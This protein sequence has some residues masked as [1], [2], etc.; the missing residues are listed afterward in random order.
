MALVP[1]ISPQ[2]L[3]GVAQIKWTPTL[4]SIQ[5]GPRHYLTSLFIPL[6]HTCQ[7]KT[8]VRLPL[9][10]VVHPPNLL[11][12]DDAESCC[13]WHSCGCSRHWVCSFHPSH[14]RLDNILQMAW[15][16]IQGDAFKSLSNTGGRNK[17]TNKQISK[18]NKQTS[19]SMLGRKS[20]EVHCFE[21]PKSVHH[22]RA[23][24][25]LKWLTGLCFSSTCPFTVAFCF[26]NH[27]SKTP[28]S[29]PCM[30]S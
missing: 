1:G 2:P 10:W 24:I 21:A 19:N 6:R 14:V 28:K 15:M 25:L 12:G 5:K 13:Q 29:N 30:R 23:C 9:T 11:P 16:K 26:V 17:Q 8:Y 22:L 3:G 4:L 27:L 18:T 7:H 20:S